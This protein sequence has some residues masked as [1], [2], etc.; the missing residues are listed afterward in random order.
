MNF[1]TVK[2]NPEIRNKAEQMKL[3]KDGLD[4]WD[5]LL[6]YAQL[7]YDAIDPADMD[8]F[9]W[10][11]IYT[12]R[13][14]EDGYFMLRI[15]IPNG[16]LTAAQL[17]E[18][19]R[20]SRQFGENLADIT[21]RQ[22]IQYHWIRI[23]A[24][25]EILQRLEAVGLSTKGACGDITR[26]VVG[27][28]A[29]G[30][31][32]D[33]LIDAAPLADEITA[34]FAGNRAFSNLPRKYKISI[35][36]CAHYC[37]QHEINDVGLVAVRRGVNGTAEVGFDLW[38]GGGLSAIPYFAQRLGVFVPPD[39]VL[40]VVRGVTEIF[41]DEGYRKS[42][43]RARLKF[44]VADWGAER[45]RAE[46]E[47]RLGRRLQ[48]GPEPRLPANT[49]RDHVGIFPQKTPGLCYVGAA[50]LRGR[51]SGDQL[52]R[53]AALA[54]EYGSDSVRLSNRQTLLVAD[55][56]EARAEALAEELRRIDLHVRP[57]TFRRG[58]IACTG[59][60]FCKEAVAETKDRAALIIEHLEQRLPA[61]D[62][63]AVINVTGCPNACT[64]YQVADVGLMG[65]TQKLPDG[66]TQEVFQIYL[67]GRMGADRSFG[68][69][70][71]RKIAA[72]HVPGYIEGVLRSYEAQR[73]NGESLSDFLNR[74]NVEELDQLA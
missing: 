64:Q 59:I 1:A 8:R 71:K 62:Q 7:G 48:D 9:K 57:T 14:K 31:D 6:R 16:I 4:V 37:A 44:L 29:A 28:P 56:P 36:G 72:D 43:Q 54:R 42:R 19:G 22:D 47:E 24:V 41:R 13:P 17:E 32:R 35:A 3:D 12:Q 11:G 49:H 30:L 68:R 66:G 21:T 73:E 33:E 63:L 5:D 39:E 70:L 45:F 40:E 67:G 52:I 20:L 61:F 69:R 55:V 51:V 38:V 46:L 26:N 34:Y 60:Q 25:P 23:E 10:Y 65:G 50:T 74:L 58:T 2:A 27:C 15:K 18:I 53:V